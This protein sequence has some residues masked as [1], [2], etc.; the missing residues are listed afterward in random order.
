M[1]I[2]H[3]IPCFSG[4]AGCPESLRNAIIAVL[5]TKKSMK[6][7]ILDHINADEWKIRNTQT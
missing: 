1:D 7:K 4:L 3:L 6:S 2:I 5:E